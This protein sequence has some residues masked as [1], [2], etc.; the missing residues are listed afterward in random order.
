MGALPLGV[1]ECSTADTNVSSQLKAVSAFEQ[2]LFSRTV[3]IV[4]E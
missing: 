3:K 4:K 2:Q 1:A